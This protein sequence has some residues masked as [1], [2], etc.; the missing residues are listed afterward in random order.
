LNFLGMMLE[1]ILMKMSQ[2][3]EAEITTVLHQAEGLCRKL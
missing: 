3:S 1:E 2:S